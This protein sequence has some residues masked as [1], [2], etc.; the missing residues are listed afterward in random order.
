MNSP[1]R[2][3]HD[4]M[5]KRCCL[6]GN[7]TLVGGTIRYVA[8]M[9]NGRSTDD[10]EDERRNYHHERCK[11]WSICNERACIYSS[12]SQLYFKRP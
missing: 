4:K 3:I 10:D 12:L 8:N 6:R 2:E 7:T 5:K 9:E 1:F 11:F